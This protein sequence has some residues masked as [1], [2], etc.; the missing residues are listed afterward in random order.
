VTQV[1]NGLLLPIVLVAILR[2][3]NDPEVMGAHTNSRAYNAIAWAT[4]AFVVALSTLYL[5][6]TILGFFGL[7]PG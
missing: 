2:L 7:G 6:I 3:V 1:L 5:A 4:V